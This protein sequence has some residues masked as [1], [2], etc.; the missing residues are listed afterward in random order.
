MRN[1]AKLLCALTSCATACLVTGC[2]GAAGSSGSAATDEIVAAYVY[3]DKDRFD[4]DRFVG[5]MTMCNGWH[6]CTATGFIQGLRA[7]SAG[8][9][10]RGGWALELEFD[11]EVAASDRADM[12]AEL[13]RRAEALGLG[14]VEFLR[15]DDQW[16][17]CRGQGDCLT[18]DESISR[19]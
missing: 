8:R 18:V 17:S 11:R 3:R 4:A 1:L 15:A 9:D 6:S 14:E 16:P 7:A 12:Q 19:P 2:G 5:P 13:T 10:A